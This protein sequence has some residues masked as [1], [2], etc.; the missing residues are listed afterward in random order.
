LILWLSL[1]HF[2]TGYNQGF[3]GAFLITLTNPENFNWEKGTSEYSLN[4]SLTTSLYFLGMAL[5]SYT[6]N[7]YQNVSQRKLLIYINV[8]V[9]LTTGLSLIINNYVLFVTRFVMG[10]LCGVNRPTANMLVFQLSP[11]NVRHSSI[12]VYALHFV[13]GLL[14]QLAWG[15]FDT[16]EDDTYWRISYSFQIIPATVFIVLALTKYRDFESPILLIKA[17]REVACKKSMMTYMKEENIIF[18]FENFKK[19]ILE[20]DQFTADIKSQKKSC[21]FLRFMC[22]HYS[23]EFVYGVVVG[24]FT[25]FTSFNC[26]LNWA[27]I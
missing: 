24:L 6:L 26:Y 16:N 2:I 8:L 12:T 7:V 3:V 25:A 18:L 15:F 17:N 21:G 4:L 23:K 19:L 1:P 14:M 11:A 22:Q 20:E 10:Y 13:F 9:I 27:Q 5:A